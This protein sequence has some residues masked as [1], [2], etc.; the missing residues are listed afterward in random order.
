MSSDNHTSL[1]LCSSLFSAP[2]NS[3]PDR[4]NPSLMLIEP[5][6]DTYHELVH[7]LKEFTDPPGKPD[8][9][10]RQPGIELPTGSGEKEGEEGAEGDKGLP[11]LPDGPDEDL[12]FF[13][14]FFSDWPKLGPAHHLEYGYNALA[15]LGYSATWNE[16]V[17]TQ[18]RVV[19]FTGGFERWD[20]I[21]DKRWAQ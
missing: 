16:W 6:V 18:L 14:Y 1:V 7:V 19:R 8:A 5:R 3:L 13:N 21:T 2:D 11:P 17:H 20:D 15:S 10:A 9:Q 12:V 4:F